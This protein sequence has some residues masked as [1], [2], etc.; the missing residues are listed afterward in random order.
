MIL[1]KMKKYYKTLNGTCACGGGSMD[2]GAFIDTRWWTP[3]ISDVKLCERGY[4]L[5]LNPF[6]WLDNATEIYEVEPK[7]IEASD[8]NKLVCKSFRFI[9]KLSSAEIKKLSKELNKIDYKKLSEKLGNI[10]T[11]KDTVKLLKRIEKIDWFKPQKKPLAAKLQLKVES[12]L[13]AFKLDLKCE[14]Q[15]NPLDKQ[16]AGFSA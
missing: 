11:K 14:V 5:T 3:V 2:Y 13:K 6:K 10:P 7:T 16:S 15:L 4:H 12:I 8:Y 9:K 1:G